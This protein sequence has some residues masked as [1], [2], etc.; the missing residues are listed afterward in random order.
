MRS[1]Y[2][3]SAL[4]ISVTQA[5]PQFEGNALKLRDDI[6]ANEVLEAANTIDTTPD[7]KIEYQ[8]PS[9]DYDVD[10]VSTDKG[11]KSPKP[12]QSSPGSSVNNQQPSD[13]RPLPNS[14]MHLNHKQLPYA[15]CEGTINTCKVCRSSTLCLDGH[16]VHST[17]NKIDLI[18]PPAGNTNYQF[19]CVP[20][21]ESDKEE[22]GPAPMQ[23]QRW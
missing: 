2:F 15:V 3:L 11:E 20:L 16:L 9:Y 21:H 18:C 10:T 5:L 22:A 4:L 19:G 1:R 17:Y 8:P 23:N 14:D 7:E 13:A 12:I 6:Y